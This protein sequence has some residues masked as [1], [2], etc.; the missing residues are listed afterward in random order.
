MVTDLQPRDPSVVWTL[1]DASISHA[2]IVLEVLAAVVKHTEGRIL[3]HCLR[4][5]FALAERYG[6][7]PRGSNPA[8]RASLPPLPERE[9]RALTA[10]AAGR[11]LD[12]AEQHDHGRV[13]D[14][15]TGGRVGALQVGHEGAEGVHG[16]RKHG[17]LNAEGGGH[18]A[19]LPPRSVSR[20]PAGLFLALLGRALFAIV[21]SRWPRQCNTF[22]LRL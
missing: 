14:A 17:R 15:G 16:E 6:Y 8:Q 5:A 1:T 21:I 12:A 11:A 13:L 10:E 7:I 20:P 2:G 18:S 9:P 19:I 3:V 22:A 4:R